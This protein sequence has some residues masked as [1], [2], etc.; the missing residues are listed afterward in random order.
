MATAL[1]KGQQ[2]YMTEGG[3]RQSIFGEA[4][5]VATPQQVISKA[6]VLPVGENRTEDLSWVC[7]RR[8]RVL[9][10]I[11]FQRRGAGYSA[12]PDRLDSRAPVAS[13][14]YAPQNGYDSRSRPEGVHHVDWEGRRPSALRHGP[15]ATVSHFNRTRGPRAH[16]RTQFLT[17]LAHSA[18][19]QP[20]AGKR[21]TTWPRSRPRARSGRRSSD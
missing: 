10:D 9:C 18:T 12:P 7:F 20:R 16:G 13:I 17:T 1:D 19:L 11:R 5:P 21:M 2:G 6:P 3:R 14:R 15:S 4:R 8:Y